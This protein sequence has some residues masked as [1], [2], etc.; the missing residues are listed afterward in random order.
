M[1]KTSKTSAMKAMKNGEATLKKGALSKTLKKVKTPKLKK[2]IEKSSSSRSRPQLSKKSLAKGDLQGPAP[3]SLNERITKAIETTENEDQA[4]FQVK[5]QLS[6]LDK[7][8]I[9]SQYQTHLKHNPSDAQAYAGMSNLEKGNAQTLWFIKKASPKFFGFKMELSATDKVTKLDAWCSEK[10]MLEKFGSDEMQLHIASGRLFWR[11]DPL[12]KGVWQ[13]KDQ[14]AI[15]REVTLQKGKTLRGEQEWQPTEEQEHQFKSLYDSDL[16]GMLGMQESFFLADEGSLPLAKGK[17][18][19]CGK[20]FDVPGKGKRAK[21][22]DLKP[23][24]EDEQLDNA[25]SKCKKMRDLCNKT[26]Q[27]LQLL[28]KQA[29][30]TKFWSRAA[31]KDADTL[32]DALK[33]EVDDLQS[34][35]LKKSK[36]FEKLKEVCLKAAGKVKE[37]L[38]QMKEY[39][40]LLHKTSSKASNSNK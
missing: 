13:Y 38:S 32:L 4:L 33:S 36:D 14:G 10:E 39:R 29:K 35:L 22:D 26:V 28:I 15:S 30:G 5:D 11:E 12:T 37:V 6:K 7:S 19:G 24:T 2:T 3:L 25:V 34:S 18:K 27:D 40:G 21:I 31:Q 17:G 16:L 1:A 9:W 20:S 8:N 23:R